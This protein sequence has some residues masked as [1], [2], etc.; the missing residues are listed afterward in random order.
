MNFLS[1]LLFNRK[2]GFLRRLR[3]IN[4][5]TAYH[6]LQEKS[7]TIARLIAA[8]FYRKW[9]ILNIPSKNELESCR[10]LRL[11]EGE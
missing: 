10:S 5:S 1:L 8:Y 6:F 4:H 11:T 9:H 2:R 7:A 3:Q